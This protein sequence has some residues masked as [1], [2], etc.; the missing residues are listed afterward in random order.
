MFLVPQRLALKKNDAMKLIRLLVVFQS[1]GIV[2]SMAED[3]MN[4]RIDLMAP[5]IK[6][7][8]ATV[9]YGRAESPMD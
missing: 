3:P 4:A 9:W 5:R 6:N 2:W 7:D 1:V 8:G